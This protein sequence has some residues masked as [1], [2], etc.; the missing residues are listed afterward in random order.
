MEI[1]GGILAFVFY[2]RA[3]E[4]ALNSMRS[5]NDPSPAGE[6]IRAGWMALQETVGF[7]LPNLW[8]M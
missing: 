3:R 7:M 5:Y 4:E 1:V 2:P 6:T 8:R